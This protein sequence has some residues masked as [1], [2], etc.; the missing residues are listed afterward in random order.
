M[1]REKIPTVRTRSVLEFYASKFHLLTTAE[2]AKALGVGQHVVRYMAKTGAVKAIRLASGRL[3]ILDRR[4]A[5]GEGHEPCDCLACVAARNSR[6][7]ERPVRVV[8]FRRLE[9]LRGEFTVLTPTE[10]SREYDVSYATV[11]AYARASEG[12]QAV[13]TPNRRTFILLPREG[14]SLPWKKRA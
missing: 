7:E 10:V 6:S 4:A 9:E 3:R 8:S 2:A 12:V 13:E 14:G 11:L 5:R 1:K